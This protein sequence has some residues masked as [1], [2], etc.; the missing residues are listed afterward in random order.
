LFRI[1]LV[2]PRHVADPAVGPPEIAK[3]I[4]HE[5]IHARLHRQ[6]VQGTVV[7][8]ARNEAVCDWAEHDFDKKHRRRFVL[9]TEP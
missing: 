1:C 3:T 9:G 2:D 5:T 4:L 6:R 8:D 7:Y